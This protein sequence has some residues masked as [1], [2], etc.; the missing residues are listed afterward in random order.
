MLSILKGDTSCCITK[1][2]TEINFIEKFNFKKRL[3][4]SKTVSGIDIF[5]KDES[6]M[7]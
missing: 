6:Y 3:E 5:T 7:N 1:D 4:S 2:L